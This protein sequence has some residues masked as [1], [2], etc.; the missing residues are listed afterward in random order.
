[1]RIHKSLFFVATL[2]LAAVAPA[3][4]WE[5]GGI[6]GAGFASGLSVS[7]PLASATTGFN[8]GAAFGVFA[9]A[10]LNPRWSG[11]IAYTYQFDSLK[12]AGHGAS[13]SFSG[14]SHA[15]YYDF[16]YH[17]LRRRTRAQPFVA[18]GAGI[19]LYRGTGAEAAYQPL[20]N[21]AFLTKTQDLRPLITV[22]GGVQ[23]R[24]NQH[25]IFRAEVL[26][27]ITPFPDKVITPAPGAKVSGW[28][29][30]FVPL[31]GCSFIF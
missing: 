5:I 30:D 9:G 28:V 23:Y 2:G 20:S 1:M 25:V 31:F 3:Q 12:L 4:E 10:P 15:V 13:A 22:G 19:K 18:A 16:L 6:G 8:S 27:Y 29:N 24:F 26:D 21:L 11:E 7:S 17:P 14:V